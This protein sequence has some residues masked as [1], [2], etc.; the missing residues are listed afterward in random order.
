MHRFLASYSC[1]PNAYYWI[2]L[3]ICGGWLGVAK[4]PGRQTDTGLV[5]LG[6]LSLL[7]V[8][9]EGECFYFFCFF[10]VIPI[11]L[12]S[13]FLSFISSTISS[14]SFLPFSGRRQKWPTRADVSLNQ[15][16]ISLKCWVEVACLQ[17]NA[18][19]C[20]RIYICKVL[21]GCCISATKCRHVAK[22]MDLV[23]NW[24]CQDIAVQLVQCKTVIISS[25]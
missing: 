9:V 2:R 10:T 21:S 13:L 7:L 8:R 17:Q 15:H 20:T 11:P 22:Y 24:I 1:L 25:I 14:I 18:H 4:V 12:S 23:I 5:W 3:Y 19:Y 6:L 16:F